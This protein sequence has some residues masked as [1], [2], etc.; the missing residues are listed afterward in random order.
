MYQ[1]IGTYRGNTE[2]LDTAESEDD[3][4]FLIWEYRMAFGNELTISCIE[5]RWSHYS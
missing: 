1:I 3:A 2:I 4:K 5:S